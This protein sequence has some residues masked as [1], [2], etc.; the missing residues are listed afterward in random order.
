MTSVSSST[1]HYNEYLGEDFFELAITSV[2]RK[3]G[4][5]EE[6]SKVV[7]DIIIKRVIELFNK[8]LEI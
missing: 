1:K 6:I 5:D 7:E 2:K 8:G 4:A 3:G